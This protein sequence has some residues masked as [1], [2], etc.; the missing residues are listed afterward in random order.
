MRNRKSLWPLVR[1]VMVFGS[2]GIIL[3]GMTF[4]A[5]QSQGA[6]LSGNT[7]NS[8]TADLRISKDGLTWYSPTLA[9]YSFTGVIP[10]GSAAP[11]SGDPLYLKNFG[12]ANMSIKAAISSTPSVTTTGPTNASVN[13]SKIYLVI[14]RTDTNV[15]QSLSLKSLQDANATGG[16]GLTD[17]ISGGAVGSYTLKIS[18]DSDAFNAQS[19]TISG[20]DLVFSG[21]GI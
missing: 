10:G 18:M 5:L 1:A 14:T 2:I 15:S 4:A 3:T 9:G 11:S 19:A 21:I 7:I 6:T 20:I 13:L 12:T 8:A 17:P 16:L